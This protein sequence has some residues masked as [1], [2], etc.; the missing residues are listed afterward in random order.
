ML[1]ASVMNT[2][3]NSL[4]RETACSSHS[5][6]YNQ[7]FGRRCRRENLKRFSKCPVETLMFP[8]VFHFWSWACPKDKAQAAETFSAILW[9]SSSCEKRLIKRRFHAT[10]I[11]CNLAPLHCLQSKLCI[12]VKL[13]ATGEAI[14]CQAI[15]FYH[16]CL[17]TEE[18][19]R[20]FKQ[21]LTPFSETFDISTTSHTT[22]PIDS[23]KIT[24][25]VAKGILESWLH[26]YF[27]L[28]EL[29]VDNTNTGD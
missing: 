7:R 28:R 3:I 10:I 4:Y 21:N 15:N 20:T 18:A 6:P 26:S 29:V 13:P 8:I 22:S 2:Y 11:S 12:L 19:N 24:H 1:S 25:G 9:N 17:I 23:N 5:F 16:T 27:L 14:H